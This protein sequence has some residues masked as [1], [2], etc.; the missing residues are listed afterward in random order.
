MA[1]MPTTDRV[2]RRR[3]AIS[4]YLGTT[5]EYYDFLLYGAA[6]ALIFNK[7][8]FANLS[9]LLGTIAALATLAAGYVAR[10]AGAVLFGHFGD[11]IG[12]KNVMLVTMVTMGISSGL[13]GLLP[14]YAM[15]GAAAPL[16]L[17]FLRLLQG[18]AVGGEFGGAVLMASEHAGNH[19]RGRAASS[20]AMG[21]PSGAV[22]ATAAMTLV[23]LLPEDALFAWGW[24]V[25]FVGSFLLLGLG[26]WFRSRIEES[27]VFL[28]QAEQARVA[29][30]PQRREVPFLALLRTDGGRVFNA[31]VVQIGAFCGQGV[32][33]VWIG[34]YAPT[35][36]Y[37]RSL[38]LLTIMFGMIISVAT[39]PLCAG[40]SDKFGRRPIV[41]FGTL[42]TVAGAYPLLMLINTRSA[43]L[44]VIAVVLYLA[45]IMT[46]V[47]AVAPAFLS[48]LFN[49]EVRFTA[50]SISY[51][52]AATV[53]AGFGP[54]IAASLL[55]MA[56]G[57]TNTGLISLFLVVVGLISALT[58]RLLPETSR[59]SLLEPT[60][61]ATGGSIDGRVE[62][63]AP[64]IGT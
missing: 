25:P 9:P 36:G 54:L 51:Q 61:T 52:L 13:I 19:A 43:P 32:F 29:A 6:A 17:L 33:G 11:R 49:T 7:V 44:F 62:E 4:S 24:R 37:S 15:I 8:F 5:I 39:T 1:T 58:L 14:T 42:A 10:F 35:I 53:G 45:V 56:G 21:A 18:V 26:M 48:E 46:P 47:T 41:L 55:L 22:L 2:L 40:L 64:R 57:G 34:S 31:V 27:P 16:I 38:V 30:A 60:T 63:E 59:R 23:T 50:V 3:V 28:A 20:A 12:R